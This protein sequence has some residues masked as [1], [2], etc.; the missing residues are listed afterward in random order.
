MT[1]EEIQAV[2]DKDWYLY[3]KFPISRNVL[4]LKPYR[5]KGIQKFGVNVYYR[6]ESGLVI[7]EENFSDIWEY[8]DNDHWREATPEEVEMLVNNKEKLPS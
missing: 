7:P 5:I 4:V 6:R 3:C 2:I 1:K 8:S